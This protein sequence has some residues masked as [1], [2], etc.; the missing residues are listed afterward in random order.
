MK[1]DID[2]HNFNE[3]YYYINRYGSYSNMRPQDIVH[4]NY[5]PCKRKGMYCI[6]PNETGKEYYLRTI[7]GKCKHCGSHLPS[8][9]K[10]CFKQ[11]WDC[12]YDAGLEM[13]MDEIG[14]KITASKI[15]DHVI[16][17]NLTKIGFSVYFPKMLA[18]LD[19]VGNKSTNNTNEVESVN[20]AIRD[21]N[22]FFARFD[23]PTKLEGQPQYR[24]VDVLYSLKLALQDLSDTSNKQPL[25]KFTVFVL[26]HEKAFSIMVTEKKSDDLIG[27]EAVPEAVEP[28]LTEAPEE[29]ISH[30]DEQLENVIGDDDKFDAMKKLAEDPTDDEVRKFIVQDFANLDDLKKKVENRF[31]RRYVRNFGEYSIGI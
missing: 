20:Y 12:E 28:C 6:L 22:D 3:D 2:Y 18:W 1:E 9:P 26:D 27:K 15:N 23:I 5:K 7:E 29:L 31:G 16:N 10:Q 17:E 14:K 24:P 13:E 11:C 30:L 21:V 8:D 25:G 4:P 19:S